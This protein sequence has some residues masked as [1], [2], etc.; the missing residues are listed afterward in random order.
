[1]ANTFLKSVV[2]FTKN[3]KTTG[4]LYQTSKKIE[5]EICRKINPETKIVVEFGTGLGN[6]TQRILQQLPPDGILYSFEVNPDFVKDVKKMITDERLCLINDGAQNFSKYI[7]KEVDCI[8]SSIPFTL[9]PK[10]LGVEIIQKSYAVLKP[11]SFF[12]QVLYSSFHKKKFQK[13]FDN[14]EIIRVPSVPAGYVHH[15]QKL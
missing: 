15:C 2:N 6:I 3:V 10:Q 11:G 13:V 12:S 8:I 1:M 9:I 7:D 4:A 14:M 5:K